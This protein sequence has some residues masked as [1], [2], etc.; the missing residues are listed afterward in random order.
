MST[1]IPSAQ[2]QPAATPA[3]PVTLQTLRDKKQRRQPIVMLTAYD[4]PTAKILASTGVDVLLVGDSAATTMLGAESTTAVTLDFL[5]TLTD[6][7]RRG[8]PN[9]FVMADMPFGS[10]PDIPT[11]A[12]NAARFVR[13]ARADAV[14]FEM[15]IRHVEMTRALSAAGITICA[16]VGLLPQRAHQQ[17]GYIAQ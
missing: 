8:A 7:V 16:H 11:A 1:T 14:K 3:Q 5:I 6:A 12:A 10:Y 9:L 4:H 15:D 17:G 2:S 13:E